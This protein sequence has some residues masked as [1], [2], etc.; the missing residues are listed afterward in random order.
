MDFEHQADAEKATQALQ[1]AGI[2][3][4][5]AKV[6]KVSPACSYPSTDD[7]VS[8]LKKNYPEVPVTLQG[9]LEV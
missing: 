8:H 1:T 4:Q 9:L 6:S 7:P 3:A 5:M 2:Q